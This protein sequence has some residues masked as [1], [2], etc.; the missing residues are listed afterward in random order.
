MITSVRTII[1][2]TNRSSTSP[3]L[4]DIDALGG[5]TRLNRRFAS[6]S[7]CGSVNS[8]NSGASSASDTL[9]SNPPTIMS[10]IAAPTRRPPNSTKSRANPMTSRCD[11]L[12]LPT[13]PNLSASLCR[14]TQRALSSEIGT[15]LI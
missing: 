13:R 2:I 10:R 8:A 7:R 12:S 3:S 1:T 4:L 9:S 11:D 15:R 5:S 6:P 14:V